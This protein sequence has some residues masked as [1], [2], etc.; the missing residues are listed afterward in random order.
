MSQQFFDQVS[1]ESQLE[2]SA[3]AVAKGIFD[4]LN[5]NPPALELNEVSHALQTLQ[6]Q[7][8]FKEIEAVGA[9]FLAENA[10]KAG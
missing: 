8:K 4:V 1:L 6:Q 5:Q 7:A 10:Q 2:V 3:E 9:Q